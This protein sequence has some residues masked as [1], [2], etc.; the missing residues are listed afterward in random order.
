MG[1]MLS[2]VGELEKTVFAIFTSTRK[3]VMIKAIRPKA[4]DND[5]KKALYYVIVN[6]IALSCFLDKTQVVSL[7]STKEKRDHR[8]EF[9]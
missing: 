4:E 6:S 5:H 8:P 7:V 3:V 1:L 2:A 9:S